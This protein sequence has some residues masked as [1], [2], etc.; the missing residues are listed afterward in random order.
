MTTS[1]ILR[2]ATA[3]AALALT[4]TVVSATSSQAT[5]RGTEMVSHARVY[6]GTWQGQCKVFVQK[7][8]NEVYAS[9]LGT[10][11]YQAYIDAGYHRVTKSEVVAGDIIQETDSGSHTTGIHTAIVVSDPAGDNIRVIDSNF[12]ASNIVGIHDYNPTTHASSHGGVA[13]YWHHS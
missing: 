3:V 13:Y 10:G 4:A 8:H 11:Y 9:N 12:V 7:I 5:Y 6:V 2:K 1:T